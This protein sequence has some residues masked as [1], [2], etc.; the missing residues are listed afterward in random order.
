M[1]QKPAGHVPA[2]INPGMEI[3]RFDERKNSMVS[4]IYIDGAH[5]CYGLEN[6][7]DAVKTPGETAIPAGEY[8]AAFRKV[9]GFHDRYRKRYGDWHAGM[10]ELRDVPNFTNIL[11]HCGNTNQDTRGCILVGEKYAEYNN[12]MILYGSRDAYQE[13]YPMLRTRLQDGKLRVRV[14]EMPGIGSRAGEPRP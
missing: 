7:Y 3:R 5:V 6:D 10:V 1:T 13:L 8:D 11:V 14:S 9:G 12:E 2:V 4:L